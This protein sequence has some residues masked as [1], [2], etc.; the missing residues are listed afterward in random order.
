MAMSVPP[1]IRGRVRRL[2]V[3]T[4][5]PLIVIKKVGV[6]RGRSGNKGVEFSKDFFLLIW[7]I[8]LLLGHPRKLGC[9]H[10]LVAGCNIAV[11]TVWNSGVSLRPGE[12]LVEQRTRLGFS[13]WVLV[14]NRRNVKWGRSS[15]G[16]PRTREGSPKA[17]KKLSNI[18]LE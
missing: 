12:T 13:F 16:G 11:L 6:G 8:G 18:Y 5:L 15:Q 1:I 10:I 7:G 2:H 3:P 9:C 14:L 4:F 17:R